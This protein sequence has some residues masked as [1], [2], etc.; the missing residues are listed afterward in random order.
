M[1]EPSSSSTIMKS[2]TYILNLLIFNDKRKPRTERVHNH[3]RTDTHT[4]E[5]RL[6]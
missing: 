3:T 1:H 4:K 6:K 2:W 5:E